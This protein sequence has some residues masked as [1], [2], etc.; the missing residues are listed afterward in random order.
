MRSKVVFETDE[1]IRTLAEMMSV[2]PD[3]AIHEDAIELDEHLARLRPLGQTECFPIPRHTARQETARCAARVL[4]IERTLD[5]EIMR[6][7][8]RA[9]CGGIEVFSFRTWR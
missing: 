1:T 7:V 6:Q 4:R 2:D 9:P 5:R 8:Q 3:L